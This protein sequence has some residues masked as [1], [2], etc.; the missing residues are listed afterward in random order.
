MREKA[1]E[2]AQTCSPE[3]PCRHAETSFV[4]ALQIRCQVVLAHGGDIRKTAIVSQTSESVLDVGDVLEACSFL[5]PALPDELDRNPLH[6]Q[7]HGQRKRVD[8]AR[9]WNL[10]T[11]LYVES[12]HN[13]KPLQQ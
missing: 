10:P 2:N 5:K 6:L 11:T 7:V 3:P 1:E 8:W 9:R 4:E 13:I 12:R